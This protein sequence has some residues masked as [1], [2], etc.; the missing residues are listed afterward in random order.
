MTIWPGLLIFF[1]HLEKEFEEL[2]RPRFNCVWALLG[3]EIINAV[4]VWHWCFAVI[5]AYES[6]S[7]RD[8]SIEKIYQRLQRISQQSNGSRERLPTTEKDKSSI[9]VAIFAVLCWLSATLKPVLEPKTTTRLQ[10]DSSPDASDEETTSSQASIA[11]V[12]QNCSQNYSS[13]D[14]RRPTS[15]MFHFYQHQTDDIHFSEYENGNAR[16]TFP[17]N[18]EEILYEPSLNFYSLSTI[19]GIKIKWVD[20]LTAHLTLNRATR[21]LSVYCYPSFCASKI[22]AQHQVDVIER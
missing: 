17:S 5:E 16:Q 22:I 12:G 21:E 9:L 8:P 14:I 20:K 4:D 2:L 13:G 1:Q 3:K 18:F 19:G 11:L 7:D 6:S 10:L 15:K